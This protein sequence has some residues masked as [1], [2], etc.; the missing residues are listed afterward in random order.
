MAQG[1]RGGALSFGLHQKA[2]ILFFVL[3]TCAGALFLVQ[4]YR[5]MAAATREREELTATGTVEARSV[6][7]S[8]KIPG[9]IEEIYVDEGSWVEK[10]QELARLDGREIAAKLAQASGAYDAARAAVRQAQSN[11]PLTFEQVETAVEQARAKV[12]QAEVGLNDARL[13]LERA[14]SLFESG[15]VAKKTYDDAVNNYDLAQ[16]K[17]EEAKAALAQAESARAKVDLASA[18]Y[19]AAVA[20]S[21]QAEGVL[22]EVQA[23]ADNTVL[24]APISGY[25]TQKFLEPGEMVNAGTP[26]LEITDLPNTYIKVYISEKKIGRVRLGQRA[27]VRV[28]SF[29]DRVFEGRVVWINDAGEFAVKKAVNEMHEHDIRSFEVK[30]DVPNPDL[31]LKTGMTARVKIIE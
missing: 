8:F 10:G 4:H 28:D 25:I 30:I 31:S 19:E 17:L 9:R 26:V 15:A 12:A 13:N 29:P 16:K 11:V 23:N 6:M 2:L 27:E 5:H 21:R 20:Q 7:A 1:Q 22:A 3:L 14:A 24:L 18:Q